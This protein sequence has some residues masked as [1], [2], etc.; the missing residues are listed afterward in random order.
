LSSKKQNWFLNQFVFFYSKR[1]GF[2]ALASGLRPCA[3]RAS[4]LA[5]G[6]LTSLHRSS[7]SHLQ[8]CSFRFLRLLLQT[9]SLGLHTSQHY[10]WF[11]APLVLSLSFAGRMID[12]NS[13]S[14]GS[15]P[16]KQPI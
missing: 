4:A 9:K 8:S 12:S 1:R 13:V 14:C 11:S 15:S 2:C 5:C 6:S 7:R 10:R 16:Q 3:L